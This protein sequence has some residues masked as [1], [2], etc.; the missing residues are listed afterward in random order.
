MTGNDLFREIGNIDEKYIKEAQESKRMVIFTPAFRKGL[1]TAACLLLCLGIFA[2]VQQVRNGAKSEPATMQAETNSATSTNSSM[3]TES[4]VMDTADTQ[5]SVATGEAASE[6]VS[7]ESFWEGFLSGDEE[8]TA[9]DSAPQ[10]NAVQAAPEADSVTSKVPG[11]AEAD[12]YYDDFV[13]G[14]LEDVEYF[15]QTT[16]E[17]KEYVL[18]LIHLLEDGTYVRATLQYTERGVYEWTPWHAPTYG[19]EK[20][21]DLAVIGYKYL[22]VFEDTLEDGS[23]YYVMGLGEKDDFTLADLQSSKE[24]TCFVLKYKK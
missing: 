22:K 5:C 7:E 21:E 14:G 8:A 23:T 12:I 2:G 10:E 9:T 20:V 24:G 13:C 11:V 1:A 19:Q 17:G 15:L 16:A 18:E 6:N 3:K 4:V